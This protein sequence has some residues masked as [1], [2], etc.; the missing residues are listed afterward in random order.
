MRD[1][2]KSVRI[3]KFA[4]LFEINDVKYYLKKLILCE[5]H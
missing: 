3:F 2:L 1:K 5:R 4:E